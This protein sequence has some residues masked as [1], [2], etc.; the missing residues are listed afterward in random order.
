M[1]KLKHYRLKIPV[2]NGDVH[3]YIGNEKVFKS[4]YERTFKDTYTLTNRCGVTLSLTSKKGIETP[5]IWLYRA[6]TDALMVSILCHEAFHAAS[7]LLDEIGCELDVS[8]EES[9]AYVLSYIV[10]E[11]LKKVKK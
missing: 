9:Y 4:W 10:E 8:S 2:F 5:I 11:F 3:L 1:A 7:Y 6:P